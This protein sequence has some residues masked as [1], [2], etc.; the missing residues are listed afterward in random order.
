M[1][2]KARVGKALLDGE[3]KTKMNIGRESVR[4][5]A[6]VAQIFALTSVLVSGVPVLVKKELW[7]GIKKSRPQPASPSQHFFPL[8]CL[9]LVFALLNGVSHVRRVIWVFS[10]LFFLLLLLFWLLSWL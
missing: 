9:C 3:G 5:V 7:T 4:V 8:S 10:P 6:T 2:G 1:K